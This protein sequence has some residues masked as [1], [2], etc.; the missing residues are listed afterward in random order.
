MRRVGAD[1]IVDEPMIW[2]GHRLREAERTE[3]GA[4]V[5]TFCGRRGTFAIPWRD[6]RIFAPPVTCDACVAAHAAACREAAS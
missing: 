1:I 4:R 3:D 6:L 2:K 5:W